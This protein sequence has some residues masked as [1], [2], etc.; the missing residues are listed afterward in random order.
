MSLL[1]I[2]ASVFILISLALAWLSTAVRIMRIPALQKLFPSSDN[3]VKA[4]ID[5]LLM[6]LLIIALYLL[7]RQ[8]NVV[9]PDW[10]IWSMLIGGFTNPFTFL[11][12]AMYTPEEFKPGMVFSISTM[13]SFIVT[14]VGFAAA[15][16]MIL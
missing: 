15:V 10:V 4:H 14:T 3:I 7:G 12:V 9:Y 8:L 13:T 5:F 2:G 16:I 11:I 6:A 1:V